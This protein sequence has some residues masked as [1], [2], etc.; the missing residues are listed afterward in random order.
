VAPGRR[1]SGRRE[2]EWYVPLALS[3]WRLTSRRS[4][5]VIAGVAGA[6][7]VT[8]CGA[9]ARQDANEP[10]G[11]FTVAIPSATFPASQ[12]LAQRTH[13]VIAVRNAGAKAIP[14]VAVTI[15]NLTCAYPAPRG[16]GTSAQAFAQDLDMPYLASPSRPVWIVDR[17]PGSCRFTCQSGGAGGAVTAYSNT[18]ALGTLRPGA[19]ATFD[20]AVT[21]VKAGRHVVAWQIA[22]G[23]NGDARAVL[24][25]GTK[26]RGRFTVIIH[27]APAP[28]FVTPDGRVV[29]INP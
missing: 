16:A 3:G 27:S 21:A 4:C 26:P 22:A 8:G 14:D 28:S 10:S 7:A 24:A 17:A 20:W 9:G 11:R 19:T 12:R 13:L 29:S 15:C 5:G 23:L 18:W 25:N 1:P 6:L 2:P